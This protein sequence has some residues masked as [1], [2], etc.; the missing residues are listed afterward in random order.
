MT[1]K[2]AQ[3][4]QKKKDLFEEDM[5]RYQSVKAENE[6]IGNLKNDEFDDMKERAHRLEQKMLELI[7]VRETLDV[8]ISKN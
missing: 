8:D 7:S 4:L 6:T 2:K 1:A 5:I 3:K